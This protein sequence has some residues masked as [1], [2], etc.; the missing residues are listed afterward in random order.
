[1]DIENNNSGY[2][3]YGNKTKKNKTLSEYFL[4]VRDRWLLAITLA[5]PFSLA[6][7]YKQLQ[8]PEQFQSSSSFVLIQHFSLTII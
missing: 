6:Y 3:E 1:M 7:V 2:G 8:V 5:L 4:I